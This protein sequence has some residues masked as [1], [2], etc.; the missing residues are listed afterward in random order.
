M[1]LSADRLENKTK[2]CLKKKV[3]RTKCTGTNQASTLP[4][5]TKGYG[6]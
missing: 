5:G 2:K 6:A 3:F 4:L 1:D